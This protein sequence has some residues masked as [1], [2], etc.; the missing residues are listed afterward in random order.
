[1]S[2]IKDGSI[3]R[4]YEEQVQ[5]LTNRI[6]Q[7]QNQIL[8]LNSDIS[9]LNREIQDVSV[10]ANAGGYNLVRF[11]FSRSGTFYQINKTQFE[12]VSFANFGDINFNKGDF[13]E[14]TTGNPNDIPAYGYVENVTEGGNI[15]G[16]KQG[17]EFS[18]LSTGDYTQ[19]LNIGDITCLATGAS[20]QITLVSYC[21]T[22]NGT[23]LVDYNPNNYKK[24]LFN[25]LTDLAYGEKTQYV[26][27]DFNNDNIYNFVYIGVVKNGVDGTS[28]YSTDGT[29]NDLNSI[30]TK[31]KLDDCILF[32]D[33][34]NF[35]LEEVQPA[36]GDIFRYI[37]NNEF[38]KIGNIRGQQGIQGIQGIQ[39]PT[40]ATGATGAKGDK[41]DKGDPGDP[42]NLDSTIY[43]T[44]QNLPSFDTTSAGDGFLVLNTS[45]ATATYDLYYHGV[46]NIDPNDPWTVISDWGGIQ[47]PAGP[48]GPQG[49]AGANGTAAGFGTPTITY[50]GDDATVNSGDPYC[51]ISAS[52][53]DTSKVFAFT[54]GNLKG[55]KGD[56]GNTAVGVMS[57]GGSTGDITLGTGL[58]IT[59]NVLE[60]SGG[61][62]HTLVEHQSGFYPQSEGGSNIVIQWFSMKETEAITASTNAQK[63]TK[64][65]NAI[66]NSI[67]AY[68]TWYENG[69]LRNDP[70]V[71]MYG[72]VSGN[73]ATIVAYYIYCSNAANTTPTFASKNISA[74][75]SYTSDSIINPNM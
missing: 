62:A 25:V 71:R 16:Q 46:G 55:E 30:K 66:N 73:N 74:Y 14:I 6:S 47:G 13:V 37:G 44:P 48:Q 69:T 32:A 60:S 11:A 21:T 9:N 70:I 64:L 27:F 8:Q 59:N 31:I 18:I 36:C 26:S 4:T 3:Y 19:Q 42:I 45:G 68:I 34:A 38:E 50:A 28:V 5:Y 7:L 23:W 75:I 39:G 2:I 53:A 58:S 20:I 10:A 51:S 12:A 67:A 54:F 49:I 33:D 72:S 65:I 57:L 1:M 29:Y 61:S 56:T 41:G 17:V 15:L 40:G 35:Y 52:G 43:T 22:F 63:V 24:Q